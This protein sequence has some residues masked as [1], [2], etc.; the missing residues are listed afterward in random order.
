ME[1]CRSKSQDELQSALS[2]MGLEIAGD[3]GVPERVP[4]GPGA[5][6]PA[7]GGEVAL[8]PHQSAETPAPAP[9][10]AAEPLHPNHDPT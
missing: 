7:G 8:A 10:A 3:P 4:M 2:R 5:T 9:P 1:F 6:A